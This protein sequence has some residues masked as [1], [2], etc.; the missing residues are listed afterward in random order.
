LA[1]VVPVLP[2]LAPL[3]GAFAADPLEAG[4]AAAA[5]FADPPPPPCFWANTGGIAVRANTATT[6]TL[7]VNG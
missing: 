2:A 7:A 3:A 1:V 5:G 4:F 6:I